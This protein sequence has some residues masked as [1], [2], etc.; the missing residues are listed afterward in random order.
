MSHP[1]ETRLA[2]LRHRLRRLLAVYGLGW[3]VAVGLGMII[4][5]GALDY[6]VR[7][8]DVG[9]RIMATLAVLGSVAWAVWRFAFQPFSTTFSDVA[10][11]HRVQ[12]RFP[13]VGEVLPTAVEFLRQAEDDPT[14]GSPA[15][16]R[17]VIA[18]AT[19]QTESLDF[20]AVLHPR[21]ARRAALAATAVALAAAALA[22]IDPASASIALARLAN[23]FSETTWPRR[24]QLAIREPVDR[25]ARGETFE[26]EV[27]DALGARLPT[28]GTIYYRFVEA[29]GPRLERQPLDHRGDVFV[30]RREAVA[31]PFSYR[32]TA[33]DDD[34][35]P[36]MPVDVVEPPRIERLNVRLIP[37]DYTGW[38]IEESEGPIR[39]LVGTRVEMAAEANKPLRE[40]VLHFDG[41]RIPVSLDESRRQI[42][43]A[44]AEGQPLVV[45]RSGSYR[46]EL[47]DREGLAGVASAEWE[48]RAV[49]DQPPGV[50]IERPASTVHVTPS[51]SVPLRIA[52]KDDLRLAAV[53]LSVRRQEQAD[54]E[55]P[56][57][58]GP[59]RAPPRDEG[60][61]GGGGGESRIVEHRWELAELELEPG[62]QI[63][64]VATARD[65][66]PQTG[67]SAPGRLIVVTPDELLHR[68]TARQSAIL[69]DLARLLKTQQQ[70][71]EEVRQARIRLDETGR[72]ERAGLDALRGAE[73][74][75]R[76]VEQGLVGPGDGVAGHVRTL[77]ETLANNRIDSPEV[78]RRMAGLLDE[79]ERLGREPL[80]G[81]VGELT[82]AA[83]AVQVAIEE[84]GAAETSP[85]GA[86]E[87]LSPAVAEQYALAEGAL[88]T[89]STHQ[90]EIVE[91]LQRLLDELTE[92]DNYRRFHREVAQL[93]RDQEALSSETAD[94]ARAT[95]TRE[96]RDLSSE[97]VAELRVAA[98]RQAELGRRLERL[99]VEMDRT[100]ERLRESEPLA[101]QTVADAA[102]RAAERQVAGGMRQTAGRIEQNQMGQATAGQERIEAELAELADILA[103]RREHELA[104]LEQT[105]GEAAEDLDRLAQRQEDLRRQFAEAAESPLSPD[106]ADRLAREQEALAAE[107]DRA[108]RR[109]RRLLA[110]RAARA[111]H[112][113]ARR[114]TAAADEGRDGGM[115][116]AAELA[117][118][119]LRHLE[120]ARE[121]VRSRQERA[122]AELAAEQLARIKDSVEALHSQQERYL[123]D[124]VRIEGLRGSDG[125]LPA[126]QS[127]S[128]RELAAGQ[129]H[130]HAET[131]QLA[132]RLTTAAAMRMTL[133]AAAA[134]MARGAGLMDRGR[135]DSPTQAALEAALS[136]LEVLLAAL[137]ESRFR[138]PGDAP[139]GDTPEEGEDEPPLPPELAELLLTELRLV[140]L[141]QE[142]VHQQTRALE[143]AAAAGELDDELRRR[144]TEL[145][146]EQGRLAD[147][148]VDLLRAV[149]EAAP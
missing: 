1:L 72:L 132:E 5:L 37:P 32:V 82:A 7:T 75:Q 121:E 15:L 21:P 63:E 90:D 94:L 110:D 36:W 108:A 19:A 115:D 102:A 12:R 20:G 26:V 40:A 48:V 131:T 14:A 56:L 103:N 145:S 83:K 70:A 29:D 101:A 73:H 57:Y 50:V 138:D 66:K 122:E 99:L 52:A 54:V 136:R 24:T 80:P 89:A 51:G 67:T 71:A 127:A 144:Y 10:L 45:E 74:H 33:G 137:D 109:L 149:D 64:F 116:E 97:E 55:L 107:T 93:V 113:A 140:R 92:W 148:L 124:A 147:I 130:L 35:M 34:T 129:R 46:F 13:Q 43:V 139:D 143:A 25:V 28:Q 3:V 96:L 146:A 44:A 58:E 91:T 23:P 16:R 62:S 22:L 30:A 117:A 18:R 88:S 118:E 100:E 128:L 135:T 81:A 41:E 77:L 2:V 39:A 60:L 4:G 125:S 87:D 111:A 42:T 61:A 17:A 105:L 78:Q 133:A 79:L 98:A 134:E 123:E 141:L 27:V 106:E 95:L 120:R 126:A 65:Y 49:E 85:A 86:G 38:P 76:V 11:A 47:V 59:P 69:A 8:T 112:D 31:R 119:A 53:A 9:L 142:D 114:M 84:A 104:R 6:L 68:L